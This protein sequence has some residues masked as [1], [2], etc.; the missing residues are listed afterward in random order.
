M[1]LSCIYLAVF[2]T[3][4]F[5]GTSNKIIKLSIRFLNSVLLDI[6]LT[7]AVGTFNFQ[8]DLW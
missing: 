7:Q 3:L 4:T 2:F 8:A 6:H 5:I 1:D